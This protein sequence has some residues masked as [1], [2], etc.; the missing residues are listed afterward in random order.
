VQKSV[1]KKCIAKFFA[2]LPD[3][4]AGVV[5][6]QLYP[7]V[8]LEFEEL[9]GSSSIKKCVD[10]FKSFLHQYLAAHGKKYHGVTKIRAEQVAEKNQ[11]AIKVGVLRASPQTE[12]LW[13]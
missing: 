7:A 13:T 6:P 10:Q 4:C 11:L 5:C 12:N 8:H 9:E 1:H 3:Q 2:I